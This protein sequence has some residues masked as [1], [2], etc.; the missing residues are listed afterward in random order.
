VRPHG[1]PPPRY[2]ELNGGSIFPSLSLVVAPWLGMVHWRRAADARWG[3][4]QR[5]S[6]R[7]TGV[8]W[9]EPRWPCIS[10]DPTTLTEILELP[11]G[12]RDFPLP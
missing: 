11:G 6:C 5:R 1:F 7:A 9:V 2:D 3:E 8:W 4:T 12:G 10:N